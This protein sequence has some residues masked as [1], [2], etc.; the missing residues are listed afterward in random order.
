VKPPRAAA[1]AAALA[2]AL[3]ACRGRDEPSRW[4][5]ARAEGALKLEVRHPL[6]GEPA[7]ATGRDYV[8]GALGN[9]AARLTVDG[10]TVP[11]E[12]NGAFLAYVR[13]P[14]AGAGY[15]LVATLGGDTV[16]AFVPVAAGGAPAA[17]AGAVP[18][19]DS[20][21]SRGTV[22]LVPAGNR[23]GAGTAEIPGR[24]DPDGDY[25]WFLLGGTRG[26]VEGVRPGSRLVRFA[27]NA[28][29][30]IDAQFVRAAGSAPPRGAAGND[31]R[32]VGGSLETEILVPAAEPLAYQVTEG[33]SEIVF[34]VHQ[35]S[36]RMPAA[37][38]AAPQ[39]YVARARVDDAAGVTRVSAALRGPTFGYEVA[40]RAGF[41][42]LRLRH[43][44][45]VD[46]ARP[47]KGLA[48]VLDAGHPPG[49]AVGPTGL[50]EPEVTLDVA[51][52]AAVILRKRGARVVLTRVDERP[53][54]LEQ[55]VATA[56]AAEGHAFVS[57]HADAVAS[58]AD[59]SRD[60]GTAVFAHR[61]HSVAL[62][63]EMQRALV[64]RLG[65]PDRGARRGD[66]AVI[67]AT[68]MPAVLCEGATMTV[69]AQES[70]LAD[71]SFR[72]AYAAGIADGVEAYFR[73]LGTRTTR[74]RTFAG[75][76]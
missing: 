15:A 57:I 14:T 61:S 42:V 74:H 46:A 41:M 33:D 43:P 55:R 49:G 8:M 56:R 71:P 25:T 59:P 10:A 58:G 29:A 28:S 24:S 18:R 67:R 23:L 36:V 32:I 37:V 27:P 76:P 73:D 26:Q 64:A 22:A 30:W 19:A 52:R 7:P 62:G 20:A 35:A 48:V 38:V 63:A 12:P 50:A 51:R 40:W 39:G 21:P 31:V 69:P 75:R 1:R 34:A 17:A 66:Y 60:V 13:A 70:M 6:P 3:V 47:L 5:M 68:W 65:L 2:L 53:L 9:G 16:R 72:D 45:I 11:V 44:P 4:P 54:S